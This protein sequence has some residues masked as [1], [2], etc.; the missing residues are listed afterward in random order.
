M[1][2][3]SIIDKAKEKLEQVADKVRGHDASGHDDAPGNAPS[4]AEEEA[5]RRA[6]A[7]TG[8][9]PDVPVGT[10]EDVRRAAGTDPK[11]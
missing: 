8:G 4:N 5:R 10:E 6:A 9:T 7:A 11:P 2:D 1:G 3:N